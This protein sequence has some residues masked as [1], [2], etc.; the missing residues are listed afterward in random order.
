[1]TASTFVAT[2]ALAL[3]GLAAEGAILGRAVVAPLA[4]ALIGAEAAPAAARPAFVEEIAV[5]GIPAPRW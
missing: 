1:M 5:V 4:S 2:L 3:A